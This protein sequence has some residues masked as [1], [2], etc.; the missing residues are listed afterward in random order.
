MSKSADAFRTISEVADWL[1]TPAHVLRFWESK[2]SQIKPVKR[3][4][5]RRYYR[6]ADMMLVGGIK[7]LLHDDG[8]T[9]KGAQ[10]ILREQGVKHVAALSIPVEEEDD[11]FEVDTVVAAPRDEPD[12]ENVTIEVP[13]GQDEPEANVLQ[14]QRDETPTQDDQ[15]AVQNTTE[16]ASAV[17]D[18]GDLEPIPDLEPALDPVEPAPEIATP[19]ESAP[20]ATNDPIAAPDPVLPAAILTT[21][22][23]ADLPAESAPDFPNAAQS[24][25]PASG[26]IPESLDEPQS[27]SSLFETD[28]A[29]QTAAP[30]A[31]DHAPHEQNAQDMVASPAA[32]TETLPVSSPEPEADPFVESDTQTTEPTA[33]DTPVA[34][35]APLFQRRASPTEHAP[36]ETPDTPTLPQDTP[37]AEVPTTDVPD[38]ETETALEQ[39]DPNETPEAEAP[40]VP[41]PNIVSVPDDPSDNME[42][43]V[44][45]EPSTL[46]ILGA[47]A[48]KTDR[49]NSTQAAQLVPLLDRLRTLQAK[50]LAQRKD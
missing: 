25:P 47:L 5:G 44:P 32:D 40:P 11:S 23:P 29:E 48:H 26:V 14:F 16:V 17:P 22:T 34:A 30:M 35:D 41:R 10:K 8:L 19:A 37:S 7:K 28:T 45:I 18:S 39:P 38:L 27:Q 2:F 49:F 12:L 46:R 36:E 42:D 6:P 43:G 24:T 3:A 13:S 33:P 9:I 15:S 1:D 31:P 20:F 4:G 50:M 21:P